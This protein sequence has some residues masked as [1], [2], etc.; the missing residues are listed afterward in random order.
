[1][2]AKKVSIRGKKWQGFKGLKTKTVGGLKKTDLKKSRT[3]KIVSA[4]RSAIARK[5]WSNGKARKWIESV[6][7]ARKALGTKGFVAVGGKSKEGQ[8]LL[9]KARSFYK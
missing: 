6:A 1:M 3:G 9:A 7:K 2:K 5:R 8:T 4:K